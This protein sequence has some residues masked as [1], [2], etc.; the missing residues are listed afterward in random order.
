MLAATD[1]LKVIQ[2]K[3]IIIVVNITYSILDDMAGVSCECACFYSYFPNFLLICLCV[4]L[5]L[6]SKK[7]LNAHFIYL[8]KVNNCKKIMGKIMQWKNC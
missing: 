5:F 3:C 1:V 2:S 6:I 8:E 4:K 7:L